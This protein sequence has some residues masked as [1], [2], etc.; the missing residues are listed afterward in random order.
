MDDTTASSPKLAR[1]RKT[2]AALALSIEHE[3]APMTER[4]DTAA[5]AEPTPTL[6]SLRIERGG[7]EQATA[8]QVEVRMGGI[9]QL[10]ADDV[11][12]SWGGIGAARADLVS[13]EFGSVGAALADELR[14]SQG[15]VGFAAARDVNVEQSFVRTLI[16]QNV[17]ISR[18]SAVLLLI[19]GRVEG[20]VRP[21]LDWRGALAF[22][23]AFGLVSALV[24]KGR[25]GK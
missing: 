10:E 7:I 15:S 25:A 5:A 16:A 14:V 19:A 17:R 18:P 11:F 21:L 24:R 23:A 3:G 2:A 22:G 9:G 13:V 8:Q 4:V 12:V 1:R 20:S 6:A